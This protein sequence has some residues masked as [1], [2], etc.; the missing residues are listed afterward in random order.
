[1]M[2]HKVSLLGKGILYK[3][4]DLNREMIKIGYF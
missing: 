4:A 2:R 1:M 3:D